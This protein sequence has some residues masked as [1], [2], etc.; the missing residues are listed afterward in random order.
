MKAE[1]P[2]FFTLRRQFAQTATT[3]YPSL[4][5][6]DAQATPIN[7]KIKIHQTVDQSASLAM[8]LCTLCIVGGILPSVPWEPQWQVDI[9]VEDDRGSVLR[10]SQF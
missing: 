2:I 5:T 7:V 8:Y 9:R 3:R 4:F 6:E 1:R 10:S